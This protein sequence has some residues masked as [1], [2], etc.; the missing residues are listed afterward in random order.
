M[1]A[2]VPPVLILWNWIGLGGDMDRAI[3]KLKTG[4]VALGLTEISPATLSDVAV[5]G[6]LEAAKQ[7][8]G[9]RALLRNG[10]PPG[11]ED[12]QRDISGA[13]RGL[14]LKLLNLNPVA[15]VNDAAGE[16]LRDQMSMLVLDTVLYNQRF[17]GHYAN[18]NTL[19]LMSEVA[20]QM[21]AD[22]LS[23]I[24]TQRAAAADPLQGG[25]VFV[26]ASRHQGCLSLMLV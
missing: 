23:A 19:A 24:Q 10:T 15:Q 5:R 21:Y 22:W 16:Q 14:F 20:R 11:V 7:L 25:G 9:S 13:I 12:G 2:L 6:E 1:V 17:K 8:L 3:E 26:L 18:L 4:I